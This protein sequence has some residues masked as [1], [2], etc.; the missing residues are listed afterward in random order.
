[1]VNWWEKAYRTRWKNMKEKK[2]RKVVTDFSKKLNKNSRILD[3][4]CGSGRHLRYLAKKGHFV[5]G[6]DISETV[7]GVAHKKAIEDKLKNYVLLKH[8][9]TDFP[10]VSNHF[11]AI[12]SINVIEHAKLN[13]IKKSANEI[14]RTLKKGG[15]ALVTAPST[16]DED[17]K[18]GE[19]VGI[20]EYIVRDH[21]HHFFN[22]NDVKHVFSRFK[23]LEMG[24]ESIEGEYTHWRLVLKK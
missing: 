9:M 11:D 5:V 8:D 19:K 14:Y 16:N 4:G 21:L 17:Y 23:I 6:S 22:E 24:E 20:R 7:L 18:K 1:M 10:F 2:P 3:L 13:D 15:L 12:L